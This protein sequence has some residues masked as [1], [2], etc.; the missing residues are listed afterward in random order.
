M[1]SGITA[2]IIEDAKC[3]KFENFRNFARMVICHPIKRG[4][5]KEIIYKKQ[6]N[7]TKQKNNNNQT[8]LH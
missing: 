4:K 1:L 3:I 6:T 5:E 2:T 7:K 8:V